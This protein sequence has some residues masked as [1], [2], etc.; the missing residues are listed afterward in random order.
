MPYKELPQSFID[1][2]DDFEETLTTISKKE[3]WADRFLKT[4]Q[5]NR[6]FYESAIK[7]SDQEYLP[8][9][10]RTLVEKTKDYPKTGYGSPNGFRDM[11]DKFADNEK[12]YLKKF[13]IAHSRYFKQLSPIDVNPIDSTNKELKKEKEEKMQI[14]KEYW[15][16]FVRFTTFLCT[17]YNQALAYNS[18]SSRVV[19]PKDYEEN[20]ADDMEYYFFYNRSNVKKYKIGIGKIRFRND[21]TVK[22]EYYYYTTD[23]QKK[24]YDMPYRKFRTEGVVKKY[25]K[26]SIVV[27]SKFTETEEN[28]MTE[29]IP[30]EGFFMLKKYD[31]PIEK[32][33]LGIASTWNRTYKFPFA[34]AIVLIQKKYY[35]SEYTESSGSYFER[36]KSD[37]P[38][39][40]IP[41]EVY[42]YLYHQT[43]SLQPAEQEEDG[44]EPKPIQEVSGLPFNDE[45]KIIRQLAGVYQGGTIIYGKEVEFQL[46]KL[47]IHPTGLVVL[48]LGGGKDPS[49]GFIKF[50]KTEAS[51]KH[52]VFVNLRYDYMKHF[53]SLNL[54]LELSVK[55]IANAAEGQTQILRGCY[56]GESAITKTLVSSTI[57][58]AKVPEGTPLEPA[59]LPLKVGEELNEEIREYLKVNK[60]L[61]DFFINK[62]YTDFSNDQGVRELR[63][64]WDQSNNPDGNKIFISIPLT[65]N[66]NKEEYEK[67]CKIALELKE[68]LMTRLYLDKN[69]IH[70]ECIEPDTNICF[71]F[72]AYKRIMDDAK[73]VL[74][75]LRRVIANC[76]AFIFV[77]PKML[78]GETKTF[79][80]SNSIVELGYALGRNRKTIVIY[81]KTDK[82]K[83]PQN[84]LELKTID[85]FEMDSTMAN[86]IKSFFE[87]AKNAKIIS[88]KLNVT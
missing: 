8:L 80:I 9:V 52:R 70:C 49:K 31:S 25:A 15:Y 81:D 21:D 66:N 2:L 1:I 62:E 29:K 12:E 39:A 6:K 24:G 28:E 13:K 51:N 5:F 43:I 4:F 61:K 32:V 55:K 46:L 50:V 20:P 7:E 47:E 74:R 58:F 33:I 88:E 3:K 84:L 40:Q 65:Y 34:S 14:T 11:T 67:N 76:R 30:H 48:S 82:E 86:P 68:Q 10:F 77:F 16:L 60:Y 42:Y 18:E 36:I 54:Y 71:E 79:R 35:D 85:S 22:V 63:A 78:A 69:S 72:E 87:I 23:W 83:L 59:L 37:Y 64:L 27:L 38:L 53:N 41:A 56:A 17:V 75:R 26:P 57:I 19:I 45:A 44:S 73:R